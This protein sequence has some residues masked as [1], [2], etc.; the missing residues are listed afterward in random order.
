MPSESSAG[1]DRIQTHLCD[2]RG[3]TNKVII[4]KITRERGETER[5]KRSGPDEVM[6][7]MDDRGQKSKNKSL[8]HHKHTRY[9]DY[10]ELNI[11]FSPDNKIFA[12]CVYKVW[13]CVYVAVE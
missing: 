13:M 4:L 12:L 2:N 1:N 10:K 5:L 9:K 6:L 3:S 8:N 7:P 11:H